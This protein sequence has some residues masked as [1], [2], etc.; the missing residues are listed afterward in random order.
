MRLVFLGPPGA[1]KGTQAQRA[2]ARRGI[3]HISTG[4]MMRALQTSDD[5]V[6]RQAK[7]FL[8]A[9]KLVPDAVMIEIVRNRLR[10]KDCAGGF[11]LDGFPRTVAQAEAL[12]RILDEVGA[13][14][15][16]VLE[17]S[18]P[19]AILKERLAGRGRDQ[20]RSDDS[21]EV[22]ERRL[23]VYAEQTRPLVDFYRRSNTLATIDGVGSVEDIE[24]RI[25]AVLAARS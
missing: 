23:R 9:G 15:T 4:D 6:G 13:K 21:A 20:G 10:E 11:L 24:R 25:D 3:P 2:A 12:H 1:G 8:D 7:S 17:F 22:I 16:C 14:L 5:P 19:D 18:V